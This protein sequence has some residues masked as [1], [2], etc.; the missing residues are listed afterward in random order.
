M[1]QTANVPTST[2]L[3]GLG[4][5]GTPST[6]GGTNPEWDFPYGEGRVSEL[7]KKYFFRGDAG[8]TGI[9]AAEPPTPEAIEEFRRLVNT[10]V[11]RPKNDAASNIV[12]SQGG[13]RA[14]DQTLLGPMIDGMPEGLTPEYWSVVIQKAQQ[15]A[16][17]RIAIMNATGYFEG[18]S[19][20]DRERIEADIANEIAKTEISRRLADNTIRSTD[21]DEA[22]RRDEMAQNMR[23]NIIAQFG[24]D[25]GPQGAAGAMSGNPQ[26]Q[27]TPIPGSPE[28]MA[29]QQGQVVNT[30]GQG[31]IP[32][33]PGS[34]G[35]QP[36]GTLGGAAT[37]NNATAPGMT[38]AASNQVGWQYVPGSGWVQTVGGRQQ[39]LAE[40]QQAWQQQADVAKAASNPRDYIYAQMLGN[41]RG[42][43]AGQPATNQ[44]TATTQMP[45]QLPGQLPG[46]MGQPA[47]MPGQMPGGY[48]PGQLPGG[49]QGGQVGIEPWMMGPEAAQRKQAMF[50]QVS[51][52]PEYQQLLQQRQQIGDTDPAQAQ[53]IEERMNQMLAPINQMGQAGQPGPEA[54]MQTQ[55]PESLGPQ[56]W[57]AM[58][59]QA[60]AGA[61]Q[62]L[63][64]VQRDGQMPQAN[65]QMALN[66]AG[67]QPPGTGGMG[68]RGMMGQ[69][70]QPAQPMQAGVQQGQPGQPMGAQG[71][72]Q[73]TAPG[74]LAV[75]AFSTALQRNRL[76]PGSGA[77]QQQGSWQTMDQLRQNTNPMKWRTQDFMR[78]NTSERQQALGTAS[79]A[80][81]SDEDTQDMLKGGLPSFKA[82]GAGAMI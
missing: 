13:L 77:M 55:G 33:S 68:W 18:K 78:G 65:P 42:G 57:N 22:Y 45:G 52:S 39:T 79:A 67:F 17:E 34:Q 30:A 53:Q 26:A 19:T 38:L 37:S 56:Y 50:Q 72:P 6:V 47:P 69:M 5:I 10:G 24:Y 14:G 36:S 44:L 35:G 16:Q 51:G 81:F 1:T 12:R 76:V 21:L 20:L 49:M 9:N 25:P 15:A 8:P 64:A 29:V 40:Q 62:A 54:M 32:G 23:Q 60:Q 4:G 7:V 70:Q 63:G 58:A 74:Q 46:G 71:M 66:R 82:P 27:P 48:Q 43:L 3:S 41:A 2:S 59:G 11:I 61:Q 73:Q 80:G 75:G 31:A 28:A